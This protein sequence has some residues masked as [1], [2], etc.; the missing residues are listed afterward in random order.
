MGLNNAAEPAYW[1]WVGSILKFTGTFE[2]LFIS[3]EEHQPI[4]KS[5]MTSPQ[6]QPLDLLTR[7]L[8]TMA[9]RSIQ[10]YRQLRKSI[11][12]SIPYK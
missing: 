12:Y 4:R 5:Q 3:R 1:S 2:H 11:A 6:F 10:L 8:Q 9:H 7:D